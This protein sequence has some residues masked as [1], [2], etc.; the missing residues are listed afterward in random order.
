MDISK[1]SQKNQFLKFLKLI[2][3]ESKIEKV[4]Y[5]TED[6]YYVLSLLYP[7]EQNWFDLCEVVDIYSSQYKS[8]IPRYFSKPF[9]STCYS[10]EKLYGLYTGKIIE[11]IKTDWK[12]Q[13]KSSLLS[14]ML[15]SVQRGLLLM[16]IHQFQ[17]KNQGV[18]LN[19]KNQPG[20]IR[21][22]NM[23]QL[24]YKKLLC[25][26][27]CY[28]IYEYLVEN[29]F[30]IEFSRSNYQNLLNETNKCERIILTTDRYFA[31]KY[32]ASRI[33]LVNE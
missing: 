27:S 21:F 1:N 31:S 11:S 23:S 29:G 19:L 26:E 5:N 7:Q 3:V 25:D 13:A 24:F 14:N 18:L 30:D 20:K 10:I 15:L 17:F 33:L 12:D 6:F 4:V 8:D 16:K 22:N 28:G 9:G 2:L 32:Y